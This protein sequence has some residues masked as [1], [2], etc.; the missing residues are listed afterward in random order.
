MTL[1]QLR[2]FTAV[3]TY[4]G[5]TRAAHALNISQP[6]VSAA[7][8]SLELEFS[9]KLFDRQRKQ[10]VL[11]D[12]GQQ[13]W[14]LCVPLLQNAEKIKT[15]MMTLGTGSQLL[16]LGVPP[17]IGSLVLPQL[18]SSFVPGQS[19]LEL[20][21]VEDD[22][23]GLRRLLSD[24]QIDMALLPHT[25]SFDNTLRSTELALLQNVCCV[26]KNHPLA[27]CSRIQLA[28]LQTEPL[29]LFQNSFFQTERILTA[30]QALG[31]V[32]NVALYTGQLSTVQNMIAGN[33]AV[34]FM[35]EFLAKAD[36]VVGIP[37]DPPMA[38]QVSLVWRKDK[39]LTGAMAALV[40][41]VEDHNFDR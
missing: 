15:A 41:F 31:I 8:K 24:G 2:Y 32:P 16:R 12:A 18:Y 3:C 5:V 34:G 23:S 26:S 4:D 21:V 20:Q 22:S 33:T 40:R 28:Q 25:Q 38:T 1:D 11:T 39:A 14:D 7:I 13:L 6:S 37:L 29:V 9:I 10:F 30:F 17:M 36:S 35:F 19:Q 27:A